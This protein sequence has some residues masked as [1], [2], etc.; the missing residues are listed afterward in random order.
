MFGELQNVTALLQPISSTRLPRDAGT[1]R[2]HEA[3]DKR[4]ST[5]PLNN[6]EESDSNGRSRVAP[7]AYSVAGFL[8]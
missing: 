8:S 4:N 1:R 6:R 3:R 5:P 2:P 7:A